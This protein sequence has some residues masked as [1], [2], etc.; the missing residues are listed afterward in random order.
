MDN[1]KI[2]VAD[3]DFKNRRLISDLL[4]ARGYMVYQAHDG[5]EVLRI[6]RSLF[7]HLVIIDINL[8]GISAF[9]VA[10]IIEEDKV[11]S[12]LFITN[13]LDSSFYE[14]LKN[15]NIFA[16][17]TKP[18]N[19]DQL[20]QA[21]EFSINNVLKVKELQDKIKSLEKEIENRKVIDRAKGIIMKK[22]KL[23]EDEAFKYL[24]KKSMDFCVP[25]YKLAAKI[26]EKYGYK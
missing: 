21:I 9:K 14:Q 4:K 15:M 8:I 24:R 26:I 6:S 25:M 20:Y 11:S 19:S 2:V 18:I 23:S 13:R 16:Y 17:I 12:V 22:F 1:Y 3:S 7:P 5:G 10:K